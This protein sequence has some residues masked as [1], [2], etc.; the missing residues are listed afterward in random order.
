MNKEIIED[1]AQAWLDLNPELII[2]HL[3]RSFRYDSQWVFDW[4][5]YQGYVDY[6]S[7]KFDMIRRT[8][9]KLNVEIVSDSFSAIGKML[10]L[11]QNGNIAFYRIEVQN[12]KVI[13]GDLCAF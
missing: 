4:L 10:K 5:D 12:G 7:A 3:D 11:D 2:K 6:I 13:K 1:F 9:S 8:N